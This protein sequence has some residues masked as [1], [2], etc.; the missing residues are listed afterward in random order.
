[1]TNGLEAFVA[2]F[3]QAL[4]QDQTPQTQALTQLFHQIIEPAA[5][6]ICDI[7]HTVEQYHP[8]ATPNAELTDFIHT[9]FGCD[10]TSTAALLTTS[11][12][13]DLGFDLS[14]ELHKAWDFHLT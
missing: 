6:A 3:V 9:L 5:S 12:H 8:T 1:M 14:N 7:V 2:Q 10:T 4:Q 11:A 13:V